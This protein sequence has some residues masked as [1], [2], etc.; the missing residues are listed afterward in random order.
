MAVAVVGG[1]EG[2]WGCGCHG[3]AMSSMEEKGEEA[4]QG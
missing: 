2:E 3:E 4:V 1:E